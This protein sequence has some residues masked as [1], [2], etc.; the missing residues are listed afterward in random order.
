M[1]SP[2]TLSQEYSNE[3]YKIKKPFENKQNDV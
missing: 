2:Y 3:D 1:V